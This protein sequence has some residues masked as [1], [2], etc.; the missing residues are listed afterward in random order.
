MRPRPDR[1]FDVRFHLAPGVAATPPA[2]GAGALLK[3][4]QGRVWAMKAR[5]GHAGTLAFEAS[6]GADRLI[7]NCGGARGLPVPVPPELAAGLR[8]TAAHSALVISETNSTRIQASG[9]LGVGVEEV[10]IQSR[11]SEQ[12]QWLEASHDGYGK[13][14]GMI[15]RRRLFLSPDGQDLRGEDVIEPAPKALLRRRPD[16]DFDV[17]FHLG[18]GVAATP[19]A[20][21]AGALLK[22]PQGRVWAMKARGGQVVIEPSIWVDPAGTIHKTQALVICGRTVKAVASIGWSFKRAGK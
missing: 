6:D 3:L 13:R 9:E 20:D 16:R 14:F 12:G 10:S 5:G 19:T 15:V 2:D 11:R 21:G 17:R 1:D 22:L 18:P 7:T 4:P 8:T